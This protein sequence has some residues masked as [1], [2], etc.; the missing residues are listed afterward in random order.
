[1]AAPET[2]VPHD[3]VTLNLSYQRILTLIDEVCDKLT[4]I[5]REA[6]LMKDTALNG[7]HE[8]DE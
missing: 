4:G 3:S 5:R 7:R 6:D 8:R 1:M 2:P